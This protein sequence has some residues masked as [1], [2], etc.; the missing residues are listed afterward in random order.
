MPKKEPDRTN[1]WAVLGMQCKECESDVM[2]CDER[3]EYDFE[4]FCSNEDC[5]NHEG[6]KTYDTQEPKWI[7]LKRGYK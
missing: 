4:W 3:D 7:E 2:A 1:A 5:K 6:T